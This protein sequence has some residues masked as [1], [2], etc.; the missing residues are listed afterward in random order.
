MG[1]EAP[2]A[3][4]TALERINNLSNQEKFYAFVQPDLI[5]GDDTVA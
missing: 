1:D 3:R 2:T 5:A 4:G